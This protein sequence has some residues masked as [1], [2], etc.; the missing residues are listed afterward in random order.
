M[1]WNGALH[2]RREIKDWSFRGGRLLKFSAP[3]LLV[4]PCRLISLQIWP[5][6]HLNIA[7]C[8]HFSLFITVKKSPRAKTSPKWGCAAKAPTKAGEIFPEFV[9]ISSRQ[10]LHSFAALGKLII[11]AT[12]WKLVQNAQT[13]D[14]LSRGNDSTQVQGNK[15][16]IV[17]FI[18]VLEMKAIYFKER[19]GPKPK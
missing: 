9:E 13:F 18:Y 1:T 16:N 17:F 3:L 15:K 2:V 10:N 4:L 19:N 6:L 8:S 5:G 7:P 11:L 14:N 12:E